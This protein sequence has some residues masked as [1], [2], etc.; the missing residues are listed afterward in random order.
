MDVSITSSGRFYYKQG[1]GKKEHNH[2]NDYQVQLVYSGTANNWFDGE[3]YVLEAGTIVFCKKGRRHA[4]H[5]TSKDGVK[6][7]EVKF[8]A[9]DAQVLEVLCGIESKFLDRDNHVYNILN[10]IVLEGQRKTLH[11]REMSSALLIE[12]VITMNR[13]CLEHSLPIYESSPIHQLRKSSILTKSDLLDLVDKYIEMNLSHSFSVSDMANACGY[14]QDYLYR[15]I[16][17]QTGLSAIKYINVVKFEKA[18]YLIQ[19]TELTLSEVGFRLGFENIQ[20][21]SRFFKQHG[22]ISPSEYVNKVRLT[23]RTDY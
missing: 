7:F 14:N 9:H 12:C 22:G 8:T 6:M 23:T 11:Y 5:A 3:L 21:F 13:I 20:Y 16:K 2:L 18:L 4:F 15:V 19:N 1:E 17:K 10:R